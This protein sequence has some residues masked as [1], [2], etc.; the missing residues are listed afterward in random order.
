M[1]RVF[2]AVLDSFGIGEAPDSH[3]FGDEGSN[4]FKSC[5][6]TGLLDIP[7]LKSLGLFNIDGVD[8]EKSTPTPSGCYARA[9]EKSKGKD[10]VTGH[11][12]L[13]GLIT[14]TAFATYPQGF[15]KDI[16]EKFSK[17]V[18]RGVLCNASYS[19]T[20]AI[21]DFGQ[22]HLE[23]GDLIV[24][25]SADSVFQIAAHED[26]VPVEK[27]YEYCLEARKIIPDI[28]RIIARP[29]IGT[30]GNFTRT[31]N[32]RDFCVEPHSRTILNDI[33]DSGLSVISVGKINDIFAGSGITNHLDSHGNK[34]CMDRFFEALDMDFEGLCFINLVDFDSLYGHRNDAKGYALALNEFD[35]QLSDV[36][37]KLRNDDLL[38][39]TSDHG[40]DPGFC[41]TDHTR[42]YIP[43]ICVGKNFRQ[44]VNLGTLDGFG[45]VGVTACQY[46]GI[47]TDVCG[48]SFLDEISR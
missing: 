24:Y 29:F 31:L 8:F 11:W 45:G 35:R 4:T 37:K 14:K 48:K 38:I 7:V 36:L 12:E 25:T 40:C 47:S 42:E 16:I 44:G 21:K 2:L 6:D 13:A 32:R 23:T 15:A 5:Y 27:L 39:I 19:G 10:T 20:E 3:L 43:I 9:F 33:A 41:T 1:K 28:G 34:Q 30:K 17:K 18:C 46:L 26:I 22:Q